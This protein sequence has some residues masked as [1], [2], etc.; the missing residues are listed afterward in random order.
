MEYP[1]DKDIYRVGLRQIYLGHYIPW[2]SN[3]HL[4][5]VVEKYG[6]EVSDEP[7]ERTYRR[8]SNL[9]DIHENGITFTL[10]ISSLVMEDVQ[11]MRQRIFAHL[12]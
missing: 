7:F 9:D 10:N 4:K 11:I 8:G 3:Q 2:E 12:I 6:F 1:D 5:L